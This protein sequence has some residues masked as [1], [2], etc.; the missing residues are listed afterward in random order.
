MKRFSL[1]LAGLGTGLMLA[2]AAVASAQG[3][4]ARI[5]MFHDV[6]FTDGKLAANATSI[7]TTSAT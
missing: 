3:T 1:P 4:S 5:L 7:P 2:A 6:S